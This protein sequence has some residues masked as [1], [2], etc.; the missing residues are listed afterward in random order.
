MPDDEYRYLNYETVE[1]YETQG[2]AKSLLAG[3]KPVAT[4][5]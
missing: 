2:K 3:D 5:S 1:C 4:E